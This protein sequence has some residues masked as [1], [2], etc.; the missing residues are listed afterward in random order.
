MDDKK[1]RQDVIDELAFEPSLNA[2]T[3]GVA[4]ERGIVTL[5]GHV[6]SYPQKMAAER[7]VWRVKGVKGIA[8]EI[9]VRLPG[10]KRRADDEIA[11]RA[12]SILAWNTE[13]PADAV[14]VRVSEGWVTLTGDVSW[15]HQRLAAERAVRELSGVVGIINRIEL[16]SPVQPSDVKQRIAAALA[17]HA[18]VEADRIGI[19]VDGGTVTLTG[20]VD[21]WD[22]R[23]AV[24]GAAWSVNGVR[25]VVDRLHIV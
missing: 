19:A 10:H 6:E 12:I 18:K 2:E 7:A 23:V 9:E 24:E 22:E 14:K 4:A 8:Q 17:R 25:S 1:L 11:Q 20:D 13:V 16:A 5:S 3:V 21:N 15:N